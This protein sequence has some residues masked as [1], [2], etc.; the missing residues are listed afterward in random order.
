MKNQP[1]ELP[2]GDSSNETLASIRLRVLISA[3]AGLAAGLLAGFFVSWHYMSLAAWDIGALTFLVWIWRALYGR[4]AEQ[5]ANLAVREDPGHAEFDL[6]L[7]LASVASLGAVGLLWFH[8][9]AAGGLLG[10]ISIGFG[11]TS[12]IM[13]WLLVHTVYT[14]KYARIFYKN[15][16]GID[17][18]SDKPPCYS[19][20]AYIA[21][22]I[23]MTFQVSDN[24]FQS[25]EFRRIALRHALLSFLFGTVILA[26][27][28]NLIAGLGK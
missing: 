18:Y 26:S 8:S 12:V 11:F 27:T 16:G 23:G 5:T 28:I 25:S 24:N 9:G 1:C 17:F 13:S 19:D 6:V 10:I 20:F 2:A 21:F 14:L 22:T 15:R 3:L 7:I 4:D